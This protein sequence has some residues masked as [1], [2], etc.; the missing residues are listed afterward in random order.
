LLFFGTFS[1][2][3][4][5]FNILTDTFKAPACISNS[6]ILISNTKTP[7]NLECISNVNFSIPTSELYLISSQLYNLFGMLFIETAF[8]LLLALIAVIIL[9][10]T[11]ANY[12]RSNVVNK[13]FTPK[14][15]PANTGL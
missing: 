9:T 11:T 7:I 10:K 1:I 3:F 6:D 4:K 2:A 13:H 8:I 15:T 5:I 14:N 12:I